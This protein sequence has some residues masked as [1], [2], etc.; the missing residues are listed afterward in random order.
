MK[1]KEQ[2]QAEAIA[3]QEAYDKLTKKQ[4]LAKLNTGNH[5]AT[6]ERKRKGF[7]SLPE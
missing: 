1:S 7:P 5:I 2:K 4:K 3:R 6:K